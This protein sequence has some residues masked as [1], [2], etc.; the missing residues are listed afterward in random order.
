M[1]VQAQ[2]GIGAAE[3]LAELRAGAKVSEPP[4]D[5]QLRNEL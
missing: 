3:A 1:P 2:V 5:P 4:E